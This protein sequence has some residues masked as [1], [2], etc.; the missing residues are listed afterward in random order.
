LAI[1]GLDSSLVD[2]LISGRLDPL[3]VEDGWELD[4]LQD[5]MGVYV[6]DGVALFEDAIES[7]MD[8]IAAAL[9]KPGGVDV[10]INRGMIGEAVLGGD[11]VWA[12]PAEEIV[13]DVLSAGVA[14]N[15]AL[16][17]V[18]VAR[19]A[20]SICTAR[21]ASGEFT[22]DGALPCAVLVLG[23]HV[24]CSSWGSMEENDSR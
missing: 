12:E 6:H 4:G 5:G 10:A 7:E 9:E 11:A 17:R 18:A 14:A 2:D 21:A 13:F 22:L 1:R 19:W 20:L 16:T 23:G 3:A 15:L 8:T 24:E